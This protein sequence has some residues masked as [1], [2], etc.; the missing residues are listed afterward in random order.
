ML[1][2]QAAVE[3]GGVAIEPVVL[4]EYE[5]E[6]VVAKAEIEEDI[7]S[8]DELKTLE[9][10]AERIGG[11]SS[12]ALADLSHKEEGWVKTPPNDIISYEYALKLKWE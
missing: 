1:C 6:L 11:M 8:Q 4:P 5:G 7:F 9:E 10:V 2:L 12:R 3:T